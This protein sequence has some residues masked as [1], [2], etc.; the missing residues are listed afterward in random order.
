MM[1]FGPGPDGPE[2]AAKD[3]DEMLRVLSDMHYRACR[4]FYDDGIDPTL[5]VASACHELAQVIVRTT[6]CRGS[7]NGSFNDLWVESVRKGS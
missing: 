5:D 7:R 4:M 2:R 6:E 1:F 3:A